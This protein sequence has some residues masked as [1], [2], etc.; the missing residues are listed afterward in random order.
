M[1]KSEKHKN[2]KRREKFNFKPW[3]IVLIGIALLFLIIFIVYAYDSYISP[4]L[5]VV[6]LE[7]GD[8]GNYTDKKR[9]ITYVAAPRCYTYIMKS[10]E[11]YAKSEKN[12]L[13]YIGYKDGDR[14]IMANPENWLATD[15]DHGALIYYNPDKVNLP[16]GRDFLWDRCWL[17]NTDGLVFATT[18][19]DEKTTDALLSAYYGADE[20]EN[21]YELHYGSYDLLKEIRVTSYYYKYVYLCLY[22]F[23]DGEGNYYIG[24][25]V[26]RRLVKTDSSVFEPI[27]GDKNES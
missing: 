25:A 1:T 13:Y 21:E 27:F 8:E 9:G 11:R 24:S 20:S 18:E 4:E 5:K 22:L 7:Y 23:G 12:D 16:G 15:I 10:G 14:N 19:F 17:C 2:A 26:D 3:L 6:E